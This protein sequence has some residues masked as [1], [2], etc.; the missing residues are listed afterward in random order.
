MATTFIDTA[1]AA[2]HAHPFR[3]VASFA[4]A[5]G[6]PIGLFGLVNLG[7]ESVGMLPLFFAPF[8][9]AGW[10]GAAAHLA[11]LSFFGIAFWAVLRATDD[12]RPLAWLAA[13]TGAYILLPFIT[14]SLDSLQLSLICS[15][16]FLV[17][18]AGL[19]RVGKVSKL[20]GWLM[21]P[22]LAI[23]G[24]SATMGLA[25]AAAYSPPFALMQG[26][27]PAPVPAA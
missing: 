27:Q 12:R 25:L 15:T 1:H 22:T 4:V 26:Q 3:D 10:I 14:P 23:V 19:Q 18:L 24:F 8:G 2:H 20:A 7:A 13:V 6:L 5:M 11:Q 21:T 16:L 9:I 17:T